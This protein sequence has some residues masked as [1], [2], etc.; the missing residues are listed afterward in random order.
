MIAGADGVNDRPVDVIASSLSAAYVAAVAYTEPSLFGTA[1]S[2]R[3]DGHGG[4]DRAADPCSAWGHGRFYICL[5]WEQRLYNAITSKSFLGWYLRNRI[6][7]EPKTVTGAMVDQ[8]HTAAHQPGGDRVLP[9]FVTRG[10]NQDV[11]ATF[12]RLASP[13]LLVWGEEARQSPLGRADAFLRAN[14]Q[15]RFVSV[16]NAGDLPHDEQPDA[17]LAVVSPFLNDAP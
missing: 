16:P 17:F 5:F 10:L 2:R 11:R 4:I 9:S 6:Y 8:Y 13:I 15:A 3:T 1:R 12:G 14:P 7:R